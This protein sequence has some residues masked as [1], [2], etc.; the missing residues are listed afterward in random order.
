MAIEPSS[1]NRRQPASP[2]ADIEAGKETTD[3]ALV[4]R[5]ARRDERALRI[6]H[7]RYASL[8]FTV[9]ARIVDAA[10]A[11]EVVQDVFMTV[12]HKADAFDPAR[13]SFKGWILQMT[14]NRALNDLR[15]R[16][17]HV[18]E[19]DEALAELADEQAT[20]D[21]AQW[22]A[23]RRAA[24][25]K[26]I[27]ALPAPERNALSLAFFEE[28]THEQVAAALR[29][30]LGTAKTRI[31]GAMKRLAPA[32]LALVVAVAIA[33]GWRRE[34]HQRATEEGA[35]RLVTASDVVPVRLEA[36]PGVPPE[37]HGT[38]RAKAGT[39]IAVLTATYLPAP[40]EG[41]RHM[42]WVRHGARWTL[43]GRLQ[44]TDDPTRC[45]L[46]AE[47]PAVASPVDEV[48]VTR[49]RQTGATP[50]GPTLLEWPV[51]QDR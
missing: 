21:E 20:P 34:E 14:R 19:S 8:V 36:S 32:L 13:G 11:E 23:H 26:A 44:R 27:D 51:G 16:R 15:K 22:A 48:R 43:L 29:M 9:A 12:W 18:A 47:S 30:P 50:I 4:A 35:L 5:L 7:G 10:A 1:H 33:I 24:L 41:E 40:V 31:R 49:E 28:L 6:L 17:A 2:P 37:A 45:L 46:V 42:A 25:Q 38:Y 39:D 3:D